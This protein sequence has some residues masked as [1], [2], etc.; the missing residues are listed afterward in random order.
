LLQNTRVGDAGLVHFHD[1]KALTNLNLAGTKVSDAG[2]AYF[3]D[4]KKLTCL[5]LDRTQVGDAGLACF[6]GMRLTE[7]YIDNTAVTDL[8]P[9]QGMPLKDI[10][11]TPKNITRGLDILRDLKSLK[12]IG[13]DYNQAWPAAEFWERYGKGELKE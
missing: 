7:L 13:I 12:T 10:R 8:T 2:L 11:L 6:K 9:L 3:K 4:C 5:H 1:C